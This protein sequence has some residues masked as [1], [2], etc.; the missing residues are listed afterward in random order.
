MQDY[1]PK[2]SAVVV[3]DYFTTVSDAAKVLTLCLEQVAENPPD[4]LS[5]LHYLLYVLQGDLELIA[6]D[7]QYHAK[8]VR[9]YLRQLEPDED[10]E[11]DRP[12]ESPQ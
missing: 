8:Q 5:R 6:D 10:D 12:G 3:L 11:P 9:D 2:W 1:D 4:L 7:G